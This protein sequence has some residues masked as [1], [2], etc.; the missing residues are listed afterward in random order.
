MEHLRRHALRP[1]RLTE[2]ALALVTASSS[3]SSSLPMGQ[4]RRA[5]GGLPGTGVADRRRA[6]CPGPK[7]PFGSSE[8]PFRLIAGRL[9]SEVAVAG[10][11]RLSTGCTRNQRGDRSLPRSWPGR[12]WLPHSGVQACTWFGARVAGFFLGVLAGKAVEP[13]PRSARAPVLIRTR[14]LLAP[15]LRPAD[16][17]LPT[18]PE[19][20]QRK[21]IRDASRSCR[22]DGGSPDA[23]AAARRAAEASGHLTADRGWGVRRPV[24]PS[25]S[26]PGPPPHRWSAAGRSVDLAELPSLIDEI[27][28]SG[29]TVTAPG[30]PGSTPSPTPNPVWTAPEVP[31]VRAVLVP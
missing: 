31:G 24:R 4:G 25:P 20:G 15:Q 7:P 28:N 27:D 18:E 6:V 14:N 21:P 2:P 16:Q 29:I 19:R 13:V 12:S 9:S 5:P 11:R 23:R 8:R 30:G 3:S 22:S 26:N 10:V 17:Q 1:T